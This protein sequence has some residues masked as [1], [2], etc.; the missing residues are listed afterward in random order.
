MSQLKESWKYVVLHFNNDVEVA[1][2]VLI[3]Q[4]TSAASLI[5]STTNL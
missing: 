4:K 3:Q 5:F 2:E 1:E